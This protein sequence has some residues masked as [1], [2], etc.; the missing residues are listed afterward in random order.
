MFTFRQPRHNI[1]NTSVKKT[2]RSQEFSISLI[3]WKFP[4]VLTLWTQGTT[5]SVPFT[6]TSVSF[7]W[8]FLHH[9]P[10]S[11]E[12][13]YSP[14]VSW[15]SWPTS[16]ID[17]SQA[18]STMKNKSKIFVFWIILTTGM[19][20]PYIISTRRNRGI[21]T[22][23][24]TYSRL[25]MKYLLYREAT[26]LSLPSP[27]LQQ[28]P[29]VQPLLH[30]LPPD[31]RL[32]Q[33][34]Q[35]QLRHH[36]ETR[37]GQVPHQHPGQEDHQEHEELLRQVRDTEGLQAA[38]RQWEEREER[39]VLWRGV[40]DLRRDERHLATSGGIQSQ[41]HTKVGVS[42]GTRSLHQGPWQHRYKN[43]SC[44]LLVE[45]IKVLKHLFIANKLKLLNGEVLEVLTNRPSFKR[46]SLCRIPP[47]FINKF[48]HYKLGVRNNDIK[49]SSR[50]PRQL[51]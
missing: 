34:L 37:V 4:T 25:D 2:T 7:L 30:Y 22:G 51:Q 32:P 3:K 15:R 29:E 45:N 50:H 33:C 1:I 47:V 26:G 18:D 36:E 41:P 17:E 46:D 49:V 19:G 44:G 38:V 23:T 24:S 6:M 27:L 42:S 11:S 16:V 28:Q 48:W 40:R 20:I 9:L 13:S 35:V 12:V 43:I 10:Q 39:G 14:R 8:I 21:P 31:T 5:P